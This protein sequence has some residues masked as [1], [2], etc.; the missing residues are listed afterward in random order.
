M[1]A[2]DSTRAR[3][4]PSSGRSETTE[5]ERKAIVEAERIVAIWDARQAGGRALW[6]YPTIG[7]AIALGCNCCPSP[8]RA[9]ANSG[10]VDLCTL[11]LHPGGAIS[12]RIT[13][14]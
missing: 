3:R 5:A 1:K 2:A 4:R 12:G 10:S 9:A 11:D 14:G 8:A 13:L 7:A 6:F